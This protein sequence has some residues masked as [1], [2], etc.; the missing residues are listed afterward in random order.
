M[1]PFGRWRLPMTKKIESV[2]VFC[3]TR[4]GVDPAHLAAARQ[5]GTALARAGITLVYGGGSIGLMRAVADAVLAG[6]GRVH[7]VIPDF[8]ARIEGP[9]PD[10]DVLEVTTSMHARKLRMSEL[11]DGFITLSGGLGTLDETIEI[12]TWRQ[13][14]LHDKPIILLDIAGWA[15]PFLA[16]VE[17]VIGAGFAAPANRGLFE[18]AASVP[19]ALRLLGHAPQA[20]PAGRRAARMA[21][22]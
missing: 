11:A 18:V 6:G 16:L 2:A 19:E 13:L 15:R 14:G 21:A 1:A 9:H 4:T 17:A 5:L 20:Q 3:G 22:G 10:I 7:G 8:L 12:I